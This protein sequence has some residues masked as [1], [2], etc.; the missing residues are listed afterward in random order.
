[1]EGDIKTVDEVMRIVLQ[2]EPFYEES[3]GGVTLSGGEATMQ[4]DFALALLKALRK[5][6]SIQLSKPPALPHRL[7]LPT[8]SPILTCYYLTSNIGTTKNI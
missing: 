8:F 7:Y 2:D 1:A 3:G 4:P 5:S 6:V